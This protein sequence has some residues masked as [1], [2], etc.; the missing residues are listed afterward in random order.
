MPALPKDQL[1]A[2]E[3]KL[4]AISKE[5]IDLQEEIKSGGLAAEQIAEKEKK[6]LELQEKRF[7]L[8][9][10]GGFLQ[11]LTHPC[12]ISILRIA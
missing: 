1:T 3:K 7:R 8:I 12:L 9:D 10:Q 2:A 4:Q 6:I 5:L 11:G